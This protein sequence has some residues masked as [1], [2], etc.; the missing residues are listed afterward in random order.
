VNLTPV[1]RSGFFFFFF[2]FSHVAPKVAIS[3]KDD[4]AKSGYKTIKEV[5]KT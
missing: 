1:T 2:Q 4:L 5:E 3:H